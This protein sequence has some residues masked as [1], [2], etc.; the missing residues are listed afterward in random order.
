VIVGGKELLAGYTCHTVNE[1]P[2][3]MG[4]MHTTT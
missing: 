1:T 4:K 2:A 3:S